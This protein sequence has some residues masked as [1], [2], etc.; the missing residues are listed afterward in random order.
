[1]DRNPFSK[2]EAMSVQNDNTK[3]EI[4]SGLVPEPA[5][6]TLDKTGKELSRDAKS[7]L[8]FL[9]QEKLGNIVCTEDEI[10]QLNGLTDRVDMITWMKEKVLHAQLTTVDKGI[11]YALDEVDVF[12]KA[13][14][15]MDITPDDIE[16][17][18]SF[19]TDEEQKV[20][21]AESLGKIRNQIKADLV[22]T[23]INKRGRRSYDGGLDNFLSIDE[24]R[25]ID[26]QVENKLKE[27]QRHNAGVRD[28]EKLGG[29][30]NTLND[31]SVESRYAY[32]GYKEGVCNDF[33]ITPESFDEWFAAVEAENM[34]RLQSE[35]IENRT[36][37]YKVKEFQLKHKGLLKKVPGW[38]KGDIVYQSEFNK[39]LNE[40]EAKEFKDR[41]KYATPIGKQLF[42][43]M[44]NDTFHPIDKPVKLKEGLV[45]KE[46]TKNFLRQ[47]KNRKKLTIKPEE[48]KAE[49]EKKI[50]E[51][52]KVIEP[53]NTSVDISELL[54][55]PVKSNTD[56][57]PESKPI[58]LVN[59][60]VTV[61]DA[62]E[63]KHSDTDETDELKAQ[64]AK[65]QAE[66]LEKQS[67]I[68]L[69]ASEKPVEALPAVEST[70]DP[71]EGS[72]KRYDPSRG[73]IDDYT[74]KV[75]IEADPSLLRSTSNRLEAIK[76]YKDSAKRGRLLFLPNSNYEVYVKK[77]RSTESIGYMITLLNNMKDMNLVDAYVKSEVLRVLYENIEFDFSEP[78]SYDDFVRCLHES[79]MTILMV[80]L[81][82]VN[83][84]ETKEGKVPLT[85]KS[86]MC[87][88]PDCGAIGHLKEELTLDL[89]EEFTLIYPVEVYATRHA[90]YKA[91]NY[92]TIYHAYRASEVGKMERFIVKDDMMEFNCICSAPTIYK[93]QTVKNSRDEVCYK[94]LNDRIEERIEIFKTANELFEDV[95][96]YLDNHTFQDYA[97]D[98]SEM[99]MGAEADTRFKS[100][101]SLISDELDNIRKEDLPFYL[102]MDVIDQISVTTLEG[103]QIIDKLDQKDV[104]T[105][106]G[107][108]A[109]ICPKDLL[110]K[111]IETKN[112]SLDKAF[113]VDITFEASEL[114]GDFD[115]DGY[116]GTDEEMVE[117]IRDRYKDSKISEE[118]LEKI[119]DAQRNIRNEH[120][121]KYEKEAKCF[122]GNDKWKLNYTAILF[123]WTSNLSQTLLS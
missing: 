85:I 93:T 9:N 114:A 34:K 4:V 86:V 110:N 81:A 18:I 21:L 90:Q 113:P 62:P 83:I 109:S 69:R 23:Y 16:D 119:I 8:N 67:E 97:K 56:N 60:P 5:V 52:V 106:L 108:L 59:A 48:K 121:P 22:S 20:E 72:F 13:K 43:E 24:L 66:L 80:M 38:K 19:K 26:R 74:K 102:I 45:T 15:P 120:K 44:M 49:E 63:P 71:Y 29:I 30:V 89:K 10:A 105:L 2:A 77:I 6:P 40:L 104:Y 98:L 39:K 25:E 84:P 94:R 92:P 31:M 68:A 11:K 91:A 73:S 115:F 35:G 122:C 101:I 99:A 75:E 50:V 78:V 46:E 55:E 95:K 28:A 1:M 47:R 33:G 53:E 88:N 82:L 116:Y 12:K 64:I 57:I 103:E 100:I 54:N 70:K 14:D 51:D 41:E 32:E 96:E 87:T 17:M 111:I 117:E 79:D 118:E 65:L 107:L 112:Q 123:F 42:E 27:M 76:R 61:I 7:V 37:L 58:T 36:D 3:T